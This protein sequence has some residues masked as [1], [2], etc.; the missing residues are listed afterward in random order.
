MK[1][2]DMVQY[3]NH[4]SCDNAGLGVLTDIKKA[5]DPLGQGSDCYQ[6]V[7]LDDIEECAWGSAIEDR[8]QWYDNADMTTDIR[9]FSE[10]E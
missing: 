2:G 5:Y 6:I 4:T 1:V 8:A 3:V 9:L 7:W 10:A